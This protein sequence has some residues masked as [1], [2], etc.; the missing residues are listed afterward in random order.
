MPDWAPCE[1]CD[2]V[3]GEAKFPKFGSGGEPI[4]PDGEGRWV[5]S[6]RSCPRRMVTDESW[7]LLSLFR[8]YRAGHLYESG[9]VVAQPARYLSAMSTIEAAFSADNPS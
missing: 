2:C 5:N 6:T 8:H 4:F 7:F 1:T 9:G 3:D